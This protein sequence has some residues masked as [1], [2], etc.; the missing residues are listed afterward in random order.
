MQHLLEQT[1]SARAFY[2]ESFHFCRGIVKKKRQQKPFRC[3]EERAVKIGTLEISL[4]EILRASSRWLYVIDWSEFR[5]MIKTQ[6]PVS[7]RTGHTLRSQ[8]ISLCTLKNSRFTI[9]DI[10]KGER[11]HYSANSSLEKK[12]LAYQSFLIFVFFYFFFNFNC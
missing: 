4:P 10:S 9:F 1:A 3:P 5:N 7:T 2:S 11:N 6:V 12:F 8:I